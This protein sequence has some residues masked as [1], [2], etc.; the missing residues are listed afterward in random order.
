M[1]GYKYI[2]ISNTELYICIFASCTLRA[3][4]AN[5]MGMV[6]ARCI[7]TPNHNDY[8]FSPKKIILTENHKLK[9]TLHDGRKVNFKMDVLKTFKH[10]LVRQND[11]GVRVK[12]SKA[13][14]LMNSKSEFYQPGIVRV[15]AFRGN[16]NDEQAGAVPNNSRGRRR[17]GRNMMTRRNMERSLRAGG[18]GREM[19]RR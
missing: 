1:C 19:R 10:P 12:C 3:P 6:C 16:L 7:N 9:L 4:S 5:A 8:R 14:I 18:P 15:V 13:D 11:E 17:T 2:D